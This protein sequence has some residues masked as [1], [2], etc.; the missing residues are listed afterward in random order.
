MKIAIDLRWIRSKHIDGTSRYAIDLVS[1]LLQ[2]DT[3]HR[4]LLLGDPALIQYGIPDL[5][6]YKQAEI[7]TIPERLLSIHDFRRTSRSLQRLGIDVYHSPSYLCSPFTGAYKKI[8]T[9]FD[10]IPFLFP[11]ALSKSRLFWKLFYA[12][13][14]PTRMILQSADTIVTASNNTKRDLIR[15]FNIPAKKI[16]VIGIGL[17][18]RFH[19]DIPIPGDFF[20]RYQLPQKFLLYVGRQDP[21]KGI[22]YLVEAFARLPQYMRESYSIVIAGK[23]DPRYINDVHAVVERLGLE[24]HVRFLDYVPD[25]DLPTLYSAATLLVHPSLY[26]GF[27]LP[28]LEAMACGTPVVYADSSSLTELLGEAGYAVQPASAEALATGIHAMLADS[29]VCESYRQRGLTHVQRYAWDT[30]VNEILD[31]YAYDSR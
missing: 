4:Y 6:A 27:G 5:L 23:N 28:P 13:R 29:A 2:R 14:I 17:D 8:I 20:E 16:R 3:E 19:A 22:A 12:T 30:I 21:Y 25:S 1:N 9:V 24:Q 15:L 18:T 31:M 26:E 11:E 7:R 10:V